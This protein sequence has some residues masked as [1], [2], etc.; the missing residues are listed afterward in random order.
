MVLRFVF[1][2]VLFTA[3]AFAFISSAMAVENFD[4]FDAG[5]WRDGSVNGNWIQEYDGYG[6]VGIRET[7]SGNK[8]LYQR[9]KRSKTLNETHASLVISKAEYE[10]K[11]ISL[12]SK[13][14]KQLRTPTPNSWETAWVLWNYKH[15]HH[16]YYFTLKTG[17]WELGKVDNAKVDPNG[18]SCLW[19]EYLNCKYPGAQ[20]YL[21]TG[22][23]PTTIVGKWDK[24]RVEQKGNLITVYAAGK[25]VT[26]YRD[27]NNPY[28]SGRVGLY[29]EDA[30]VLFDNIAVNNSELP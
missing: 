7:K 27:E 4:E 16:F 8:M 23:S 11:N 12:R 21:R 17:G 3:Q 5:R 18:P 15:D 24:I 30:S 6:R 14:V 25:K 20:R 26:E 13:T 10:T 1:L 28:F 2:K 9:P 22:S 19:P 29:N